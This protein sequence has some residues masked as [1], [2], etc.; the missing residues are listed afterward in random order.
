MCL[1]QSNQFLLLELDTYF[2]TDRTDIVF[3]LPSLPNVPSEPPTFV[4]PERQTA[5]KAEV[6][7][8]TRKHP[9][10]K[11]VIDVFQI[12]PDANAPLPRP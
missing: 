12:Q 5:K 10:P 9:E 11:P 4:E 3:A 1:M 6:M 2:Q 8:V 7:R